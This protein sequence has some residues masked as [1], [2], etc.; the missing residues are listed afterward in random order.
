[1]K[2]RFWLAFKNA[3]NEYWFAE[4]PVTALALFRIIFG[5]SLLVFYLPYFFYFQFGD[6]YREVGF[7]WPRSFTAWSVPNLPP[8]V[9]WP[10]ISFAPASFWHVNLFSLTFFI[11]IVLVALGYKTKLASLFGFFLNVYLVSVTD[12]IRVDT[13]SSAISVYFLFLALAPSGDAWSLDAKLRYGKFAPVPMPQ[14]PKTA[15]QLM[16]VQLA[17]MYFSNALTK[18]AYVFPA[19]AS[20]DMIINALYDPAW[21]YPALIPFVENF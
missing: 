16:V 10:D 7:L 1:M 13:I 5:V 4:E 18:V 17:L 9:F 20:G 19:W 2:T 8:V 15:R 21:N 6:F 11:C 14:A 12:A 3:W